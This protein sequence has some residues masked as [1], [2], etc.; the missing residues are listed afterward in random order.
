MSC[1]ETLNRCSAN[2]MLA[3]VHVNFG[4]PATFGFEYSPKYLL[5]K[6]VHIFARTI[7]KESEKMIFGVIQHV[8]KKK[9]DSGIQFIGIFLILEYYI[10]HH[11]D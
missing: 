4:R 6:K 3:K 9:L 8:F 7:I 1:I 11:M 10:G 5:K 2:T